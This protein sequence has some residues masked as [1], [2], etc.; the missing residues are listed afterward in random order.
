MAAIR[1][2]MERSCTIPGCDGRMRA[3]AEIQVDYGPKSHVWQCN[4]NPEHTE[5]PSDAV[6]SEDDILPPN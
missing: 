3:G 2:G 6:I 4:A 5:S 1:S